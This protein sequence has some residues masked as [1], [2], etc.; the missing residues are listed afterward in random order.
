MTYC[1][2]W[3]G[4]SGSLAT[5][6]PATSWF[7]SIVNPDVVMTGGSLTS[8]TVTLIVRVSEPPA[9]SSTRTCTA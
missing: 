7:S 3:A 6:D 4:R 8:W 5:T 1:K 2:V 9:P